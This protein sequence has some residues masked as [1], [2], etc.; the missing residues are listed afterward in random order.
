M[1]PGDDVSFK[2]HVHVLQVE[3]KKTR[4][5]Q[6]VVDDLM[7]GTFS[8]RRNIIMESLNDLDSIFDQFPFL[9][10]GDQV[11]CLH[12]H[13]H[14]CLNHNRAIGLEHVVVE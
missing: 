6:A 11:N 10:E 12:P 8:F 5:N 9:Q 14:Y 2:R 3:Y 1:V 4:R 7:T 13:Y